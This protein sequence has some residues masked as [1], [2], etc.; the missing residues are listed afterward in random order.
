MWVLKADS[1][2]E[3]SVRFY[4]NPVNRNGW[5]L[6]SEYETMLVLVREEERMVV[7]ILNSA[8]SERIIYTVME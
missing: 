4:H 1:Q 3:T 8:N 5:K 2:K 6:L 7:S